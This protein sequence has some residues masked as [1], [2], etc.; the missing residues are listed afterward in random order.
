MSARSAT[1][2][3][4]KKLDR[5]N[6]VQHQRNVAPIFTSGFKAMQASEILIVDFVTAFPNEIMQIFSSVALTK[7]IAQNLAIA[8]TEFVEELEDGEE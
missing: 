4:S 6:Q 8:L 5:D 1:K 2:D 3:R 7:D